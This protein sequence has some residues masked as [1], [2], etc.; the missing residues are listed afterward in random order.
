MLSAREHA[1]AGEQTLHTGIA[2]DATTLMP[3]DAAKGRATT[4]GEAPL[5]WDSTIRCAYHGRIALKHLGC[6][7][8]TRTTMITRTCPLSPLS[9]SSHV[10][11]QVV[12]KRRRAFVD[13]ATPLQGLLQ[14]GSNSIYAGHSS[15]SQSREPRRR[16]RCTARGAP[17]LCQLVSAR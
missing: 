15:D 5:R 9:P 8:P 4:V 2:I 10:H 12:N 7:A 17:K 14:P 13:S 6:S 1:C 3:V 11:A 16:R